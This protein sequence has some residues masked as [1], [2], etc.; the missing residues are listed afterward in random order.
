[1]QQ[2][3]LL[4]DFYKISHRRL[5]PANTQIV[6][7]TWTPRASLLPGVVEVV[8]FGQQMFIKK[9]LVSYFNENFFNQP[10]EKIVADYSRFIKYT[11]GEQNPETQHIQDL[12]ALGYL[13]L[14]IKSLP[15]GTLVPIR[16]PMMTIENTNEKFFWLTNYIETLL[17]SELWGAMTSATIAHEYKKLLIKAAQETGGDLEFVN[18][19][20]HDFSMRGM[21]G[22]ES[23]TT[24]G[25][26]HLVSFVGTDTMPAIQAMETYYNANIETELVGT[27]I[28]ASEHSQQCS[29]NDDMEYFRRTINEV[30]PSGF[31]SIVSDG[32]DFW[33]VVGNVLP[34]LKADIMK[35]DGKVVIRPDSGDPVKIICGAGK[36]AK[37]FEPFEESTAEERLIE[38]GLVECLWDIFGGTVNDAGFKVLNSHIGCIYGDSITRQRADEIS[39][40]LK[41]KGFASTNVVY[42][43]GSFTYQYNTRDT[44]GFA[45]KSTLTKRNDVEIPIAKDPKTDDGTKKS[46]KGAVAVYDCGNRISWI[47]S[48]SLEN[49]AVFPGNML[50]EIFRDGKL[51]VDESLATIRARLA[52]KV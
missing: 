19:Q 5:Y 38:K 17:S 47:D 52:E 27:S 40:Q 20:A 2:A 15:E 31:V 6:Y 7:S 10:I 4:T 35:R 37:Y 22:I 44:F 16:T 28:P 12:H 41:E 42:G 43:I 11:L 34:A 48:L 51:L 49:A 24:S 3:M 32:Y 18:F 33:N 21:R 25:M 39:K 29:Y 36:S 23:A 9:Y 46:Q 1:M 14:S 50:Q 45:V 30:H 13:P 26:G 8:S